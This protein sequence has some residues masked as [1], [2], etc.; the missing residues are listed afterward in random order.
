[1]SAEVFGASQY[2]DEDRDAL[3]E[4][5]KV[6]SLGCGNPTAVAELHPG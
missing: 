1:M 4:N 5:A 6:V 2:A 3:P